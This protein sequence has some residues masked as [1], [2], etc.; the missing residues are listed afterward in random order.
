MDP[1][2]PEGPRAESSEQLPQTGSIVLDE[3]AERHNL[4]TPYI[5]KAGF[6]ALVGGDRESCDVV[7]PGT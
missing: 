2:E 3:R 6:D 5:K 7:L 4:S 1:R